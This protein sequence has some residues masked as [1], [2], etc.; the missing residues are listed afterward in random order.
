M[1]FVIKLVAAS[2]SCFNII[3]DMPSGLSALEFLEIRIT[4]LTSSVLKS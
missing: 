4:S 1:R 2:P 3:A